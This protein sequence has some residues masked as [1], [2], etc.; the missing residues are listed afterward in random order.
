MKY[1]REEKI[2]IF[3]YILQ[4]IAK[5]LFFALV[6]YYFF[7]LPLSVLSLCMPIISGAYIL[8][9]FIDTIL[10]L[11]ADLQFDEYSLD[12]QPINL[13]DYKMKVKDTDICG[14]AK[15]Y[16]VRYYKENKE[17]KIFIY[18]YNDK[19]YPVEDVLFCNDEEE[20]NAQSNNSK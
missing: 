16:V 13:F 12:S 20:L 1:T 19:L 15:G 4:S 8:F 10:T 17:K 2:A 18:M 6:F 11:T 14:Y 7:K 3:I 5:V 9:I